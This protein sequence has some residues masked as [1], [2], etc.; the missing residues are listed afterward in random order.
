[1]QTESD[2]SMQFGSTAYNACPYKFY[3]E[4]REAPGPVRIEAANLHMISRYEDVKTAAR[5]YRTFSSHR[6]AFGAGDP[7]LEAIM[8]QGWPSTGALVTSDPPEHSRYRKLVAR[9]F[10][11]SAVAQYEPLVHEVVRELIDGFE[12]AGEVELMGEF[13]IPLSVRII[14]R[15]MGVPA[16]DEARFAAWADMIAESVS[17]FLTRDRALECARGLVDMQ[18]YFADLIEKRRAAPGDDL[19][20][21]LVTAEEEDAEPLTMSELLEI[22]RIFVAGGAESTASLLG[23][24]ILLLLTHRD[25]YEELLV[26][27]ALIEPALEE[28]LRLE[29]P[30]QWNPRVLESHDGIVGDGAIAQGE[31]AMLCW[32]AANRDAAAYGDNAGE[33]DI[34]RKGPQHLAFGHGYHFCVGAQL[35][36]TEASIAVNALLNRLPNLELVVPP[37]E[38]HFVG[39]GVVR[40]LAKLPLKFGTAI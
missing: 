10:T 39:H 40:R 34:R 9:G 37:S 21:R 32:G 31:R 11:A 35:A 12:H 23:S 13:A 2:D 14:S 17:G 1:M 16:E 30:V 22:T 7:E 25:Q 4:A 5:D 36:R 24:V 18:H 28:S 38:V 29:S 19:I 6:G 26:N 33:F 20:S 27:R 8:K 3:A 15:V